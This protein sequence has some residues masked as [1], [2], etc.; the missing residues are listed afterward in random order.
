MFRFWKDIQSLRKADILRMTSPGVWG[1]L[2]KCVA[3]CRTDPLSC[4]SLCT[5]KCISL[6]YFPLTLPYWREVLPY[7]GQIGMSSLKAYE[8][9]GVDLVI[10]VSNWVWFFHSSLELSK[11]LRRSVVFHH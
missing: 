7:I 2:C 8:K 11:F 9:Y 5:L 3:L 6:A 10:F 1:D 4:Q